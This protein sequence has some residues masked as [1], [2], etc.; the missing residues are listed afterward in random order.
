MINKNHRNKLATAT[1]SIIMLTTC[2]NTMLLHAKKLPTTNKQQTSANSWSICLNTLEQKI[3]KLVQTERNLCSESTSN[4]LLIN[5]THTAKLRDWVQSTKKNLSSYEPKKMERN[6]EQQL[7]NIQ[8]AFQELH[9][10]LEGITALES[11]LKSSFHSS[12]KQKKEKLAL[13]KKK[14][15]TAKQN[16]QQMMTASVDLSILHKLA[17]QSKSSTNWGELYSKLPQ[18]YQDMSEVF[19]TIEELSTAWTPQANYLSKMYEV[20]LKMLDDYEN[21]TITDTSQS[22]VSTTPTN[23]STVPSENYR[24]Q[25]KS[26]VAS[27][28]THFLEELNYYI[29]CLDRVDIEKQPVPKHKHYAKKWEEYKQN[30][31]QLAAAYQSLDLQK[32]NAN[33]QVSPS[34]VDKIASKY[35]GPLRIYGDRFDLAP[36][37]KEKLQKINDPSLNTVNDWLT[38]LIDDCQ[39]TPYTKKTGLEK[40]LSKKNKQVASECLSHVVNHD[41]N[42]ALHL[43]SI[44]SNLKQLLLETLQQL[45]KD[46]QP[47]DKSHDEK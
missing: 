8:T 9:Q 31:K 14:I 27:S 1:L 16:I 6:V 22:S 3:E 40:S 18:L 5:T 23:S 41:Q 11:L 30:I 24:S 12:P 35:I 33:V 34:N 44:R 32:D 43:D 26:A 19:D 21:Y 13:F 37:K 10:E 4:S 38:S 28:F 42:K 20:S 47:I 7:S 15:R 36:Y 39:N 29:I 45:A 46:S 17:Q 25:T 2:S